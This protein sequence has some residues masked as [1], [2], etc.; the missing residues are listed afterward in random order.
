MPQSSPS[1][2]PAA[3]S[4]SPFSQAPKN[5]S[6]NMR[7]SSCA[8]RIMCE[9]RDVT[10]PSIMTNEIQNIIAEIKALTARNAEITKA[11]G[12][13]TQEQIDNEKKAWKLKMTLRFDHGMEI[14]TY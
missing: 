12:F 14:G 1:R 2:L 10:N 11:G 3:P 9:Y 13:F 4:S 5:K 7:N 8:V 6:H